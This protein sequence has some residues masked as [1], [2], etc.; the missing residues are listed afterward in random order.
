MRDEAL[1][2]H[3]RRVTAIS[4]FSGA[5]VSNK[6][7]V[8]PHKRGFADLLAA[9]NSAEDARQ[10]VPLCVGLSVALS[11]VWDGCSLLDDS[12]QSICSF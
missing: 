9:M 4:L 11:C 12:K 7:G 2:S 3:S 6:C 5:R 10:L 1:A 8:S